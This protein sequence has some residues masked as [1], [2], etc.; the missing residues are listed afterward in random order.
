MH[1]TQSTN[2]VAA[3]Q[4]SLIRAALALVV[5]ACGLSLR[6]YG[7]PLGLSA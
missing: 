4:I 5:M 6:W 7:F 1:G 2:P 3:I